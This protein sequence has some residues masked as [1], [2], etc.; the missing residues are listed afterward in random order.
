MNDRCEHGGADNADMRHMFSSARVL[1][2]PHG[3]SKS[4]CRAVNCGEP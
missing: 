1:S 3:W 2:A 4:P